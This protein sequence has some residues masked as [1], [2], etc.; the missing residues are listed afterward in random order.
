MSPDQPLTA[1]DLI[2]TVDCPVEESGVYGGGSGVFGVRLDGSACVFDL[3][4][5][6][7]DGSLYL[8]NRPAITAPL[9]HVIR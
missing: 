2:V 4:A 6:I 1:R 5:A 9:P 7:L 8:W 3:I